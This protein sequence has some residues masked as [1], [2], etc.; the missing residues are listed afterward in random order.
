MQ[1]LFFI[2]VTLLQLI[3][4]PILAQEKTV[5]SVKAFHSIEVSSGL[6]LFLRQ[7]DSCYI[8][9]VCDQLHTKQIITQTEDSILQIRS[10]HPM[11][12]GF[13]KSPKVYLVF[14]DLKSLIATSG[15]DVYGSGVFELENL[16]VSAHSGTDI[17][18]TI[19]CQKVKV[20]ASGGSDIKLSGRAHSLKANIS[21]G[22]DLNAAD[23]KTNNC[24]IIASGGSDAIVNAAISL[25]A[26]ASGGSDIGYIGTP[27]IKEL[28]ETGGSAIYRR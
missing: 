13:D 5:R 14:K 7:G 24:D 21:S 8:E 28:L 11:R 19:A 12:W 16:S 15:V 25:Y 23:L 1:R 3:F 27:H 26:E 4:F 17:Y 18:I 10:T 20:N 2:F 9:L 6:D 22:S